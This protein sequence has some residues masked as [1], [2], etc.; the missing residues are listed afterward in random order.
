MFARLVEN[1]LYL[2][3]I[4]SPGQLALAAIN[5]NTLKI[6]HSS[7]GHLGHQN[8]IRLAHMSQGIDLSQPPPQDVYVP[9]TEANMRVEPHTDMIQ[10]GAAVG[11]CA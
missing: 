2:M 10:P 7:L 1:N 6:W 9:C 8:I 3:D 11:P 4:F 5:K